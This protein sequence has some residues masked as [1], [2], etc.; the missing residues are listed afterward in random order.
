MEE[1]GDPYSADVVDEANAVL[2]E[3]YGQL[4][5]Y[6]SAWAARQAF[7]Q[8]R[9][10]LLRP[11]YRPGWTP[12]W[13][14]T[15]EDFESFEDSIQLPPRKHLID[16]MRMSDGKLVYIKRVKTGDKEPQI[17]V[18]LSSMRDTRNHSVPVLDLFEDED[19]PTISYMVM[20]FL[21]LVDEPPF[22][23]VENVVDFVQ[24]MLEGLVFLHEK[25]I[26]HRDCT[27]KNLMMDADVLY[28]KGYHPVKITRQPDGVTLVKRLPRTDIP[29]RYY[30]VDFGISSYIPPDA[31]P[32]LVV[33]NDGRDQEVPELSRTKPYDPFKVD[34]FILGNVFR[35]HLLE[36]YANLE[37]LVPLVESMTLSDPAARP[38]ASGA[39]SHWRQICDEVGTF[40]RRWRLKPRDEFWIP[41][42]V[43]DAF[44]LVRTTIYILKSPLRWGGWV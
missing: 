37:F 27:Y 17:A 16:A 38:N 20:P 32:K 42:L 44:A 33:G 26:A 15:G 10:Y 7:L 30:Y 21:H 34:I 25:G 39:F 35:H 5:S 1:D 36:Q 18:M 11:R 14:G 22:E 23:S 9:G 3:I 43:F 31:H 24:Q 40:Q 12:S 8:S 29:I 19:D 13:R 4:D 6:E 41:A 2:D 28:P